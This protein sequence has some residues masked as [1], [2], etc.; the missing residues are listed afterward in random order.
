[1]KKILKDKLEWERKYSDLEKMSLVR[2]EEYNIVKERDK[3]NYQKITL[4]EKELNG[5][6]F[7]KRLW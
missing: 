6:R 5:L 4:L 1:L 7:E 2:Q 3:E